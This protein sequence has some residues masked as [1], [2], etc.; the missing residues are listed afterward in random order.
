M[1]PNDPIVNVTAVP[2]LDKA[3][4]TSGRFVLPVKVENHGARTLHDLKVELS[5]QPPDDAPQTTDA[6]I[7]YLGEHSEQV[8]YFYFE[9]D[10]RTLKVEARPA[11]YRLE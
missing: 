6:L 11:S 8:L 3:Q 9:E 2:L 5:F 7:D 1:E 4:E 10:P